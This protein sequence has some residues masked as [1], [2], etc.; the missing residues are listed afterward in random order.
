[1]IFNVSYSPSKVSSKVNYEWV[2]LFIVLQQQI[3]GC[4][5]VWRGENLPW[6][7]S[8]MKLERGTSQSCGKFT[9]GVEALSLLAALYRIGTLNSH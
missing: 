4:Q 1:M 9:I 7:P 6:T 5:T 2:H 8:T 3:R